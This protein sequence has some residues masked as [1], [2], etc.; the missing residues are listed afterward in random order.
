MYLGHN[1]THVRSTSSESSNEGLDVF[2]FL[3]GTWWILLFVIPAIAIAL[4]VRRH[5]RK[6]GE[7]G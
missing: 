2:R 5:R 1:S 7:E 3:S 6:G 4:L